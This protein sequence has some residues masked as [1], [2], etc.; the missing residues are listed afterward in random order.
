[1]SIS[2]HENAQKSFTTAVGLFPVR[3]QLYAA[4]S[5]DKIRQ[6]SCE[7]GLFEEAS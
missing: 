3:H 5:A 2:W 6:A 1:M 4:I 7:E